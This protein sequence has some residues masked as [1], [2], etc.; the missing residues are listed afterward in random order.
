MLCWESKSQPHLVL[1]DLPESQVE[2]HLTFAEELQVAAAAAG[3][4]LALNPV[5]QLQFDEARLKAHS[6]HG[7]SG[8]RHLYPL[9]ENNNASENTLRFI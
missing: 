8:G 1:D 2:I 7:R 6:S 5:G 9:G 4:S 3:L